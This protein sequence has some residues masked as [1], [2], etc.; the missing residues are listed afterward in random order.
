MRIPYGFTLTNNGTL[1][2]NR[3]DADNVAL[4]F[5]LYMAGAS[6]GKVADM[7]FFKT[8]TVSDWKGKMDS[9]RGRP[10]SF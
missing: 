10:S 2:I 5:D 9:C 8:N 6:L 1:E 3:S 7:L 4:V